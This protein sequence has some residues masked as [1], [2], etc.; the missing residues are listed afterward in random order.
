MKVSCPICKKIVEWDGN[1]FRP[2]CS[3]R[4]R[5]IDLHSWVSEQYRIAGDEAP[6]DNSEEP[7]E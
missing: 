7:D 1:E 3:E 6:D 2:F 4:C 5:N